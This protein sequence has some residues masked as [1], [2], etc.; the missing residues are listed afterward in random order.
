[1]AG[2]TKKAAKPCLAAI[3]DCRLRR[4]EVDGLGAACV[5][6]DVEGYALAFLEAA[7][8]RGFNRCRMDEYVL[9]AAFRGDKS[10]AFAGIEK[11]HCSDSHLIAP[12][13]SGVAFKPSLKRCE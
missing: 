7:H 6:L 8:A 5:R 1:M 2:P 13:A 11:L 4:P 3:L 9:R 10:K 12:Y